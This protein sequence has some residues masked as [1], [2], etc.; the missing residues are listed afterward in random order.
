M[1]MVNILMGA[2]V[3]LSAALL[4]AAEEKPAAPKGV[5]LVTTR[6]AWHC[7][8][9]WQEEFL[10]WKDGTVTAYEK[11]YEGKVFK[12]LA[13]VEKEPV[14][15]ALP[16][17]DWTGVRFDDSTWP[18]T[19]GP[20]THQEHLRDLAALCLR[21][22][23]EI[24]NPAATGDLTLTLSYRGGAVAYLNGRE[25]GRKD[26]PE[27]DLKAT[28]PA[29]PYPLEAYQDKE[30]LL[31]STR[32]RGKQKPPEGLALRKRSATITIPASSLR[33]GINVL[34]IRLHRAPTNEVA[35]TAKWPP[36]GKCHWTLIG[37]FG[38]ELTAASGEAV[39]PAPFQAWTGNPLY[40]AW[41][42]EPAEPGRPVGTIRLEG[43]R[44]GVFSG[45]VM[46]RMNVPT[47]KLTVAPD[48]LKAG[49]AAIPASA[50]TVRW[51]VPSRFGFG[52]Y[53]PVKRPDVYYTEN[54]LPLS[55]LEDAIPESIEPGRTGAAW[56]TLSVPGD[57]APGD[58]TGTVRVSAEG[59][60][61]V[62]VPV[63]LHV[64]DFALPS[65][66]ETAT[67]VGLMESPESVALTYEVP[68]WSDE[69]WKHMDRVF[70]LLGQVDVK[71]VFLPLIGH[72]NMGND[73]SL[74]RWIKQ[75]DGS[76]THDFTRVE[77]YL[78]I[79]VKHLGRIPVVC[80][81]VWTPAHGGGAF[82]KGAKA[83]KN[84]KPMFYTQVDAASGEATA[85]QGPDWGTPES[86]PFWKPVLEGVM[87][88][89]KERKLEKSA[90]F[91]LLADYQ[92]SI[93][94]QNDLKAI[95]P[96]L[97]WMVHAHGYLRSFSGKP[98]FVAAQ[99]WGVKPLKTSGEQHKKYGWQRPHFNTVFPRSGAGAMGHVHAL[100]P[101]G[102]FH[103]LIE[104]YQASGYMGVS[105]LGA[106]F[107]P[108]VKNKKGQLMT[109][110]GRHSVKNRP[111]PPTL[112]NPA[113]LYPGR[114]GAVATTRFELMREGVQEAETRVYLEK[115]IVGK[116]LEGELAAK[117]QKMLDDRVRAIQAGKG[118]TRH[119]IG[120][121]PSWLDYG[122]TYH[123]RTR[124]LYDT[125]AK[126]KRSESLKSIP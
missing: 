41:D 82:G 59:I 26:M 89:L 126:I 45:V 85:A 17:D 50:W 6:S 75:A 104:G 31:L 73:E 68:L 20:I 38:A 54:A 2:T 24:H 69:H 83:A 96:D 88:R 47:K 113:L 86:V 55:V 94:T 115:L 62:Q 114:A 19:P 16:S 77:K 27:G 36:K 91:G 23:F 101:P 76:F 90:A 43:A 40:D 78:D 3:V 5:T 35:H 102:T 92:P 79:A 111:G 124:L 117:A 108:C 118:G 15:S 33:K 48:E 10:I 61:P 42:Q 60:G 13:K 116:K 56:L 109:V 49:E 9:V 95:L 100:C 65:P 70:A 98:T 72:T 74:V 34:A 30:G 46:M 4:F 81:Y 99:V 107:W 53:R 37:M 84:W 93:A 44:N 121:I 29:S 8:P 67:Y 58:Y 1:R 12:G 28:T 25:I 7:W 71:S 97:P 110:I 14:P 112:S 64:A 18:A 63:A 120:S 119:P 105:R 57:A 32:I 11:K 22:R 21:T 106:D 125:A 66:D 87:E 39:P 51:A 123:D 52:R 80:L 103:A 122:R